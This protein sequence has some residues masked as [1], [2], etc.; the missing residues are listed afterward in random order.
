MSEK[1]AEM[2]DRNEPLKAV[3]RLA[4]AWLYKGNVVIPKEKV[5]FL[6]L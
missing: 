3:E 5:L 4:L 1:K 6:Q 2:R